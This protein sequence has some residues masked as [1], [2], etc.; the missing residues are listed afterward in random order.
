M[1]PFSLTEEQIEEVSGAYD[2]LGSNWRPRYPGEIT[3]GIGETGQG[4]PY[5]EMMQ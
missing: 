5:Y 2:P 3:F 4:Y 1:H